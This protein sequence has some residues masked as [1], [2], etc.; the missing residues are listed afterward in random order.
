MHE[1]GWTKTVR[2][3]WFFGLFGLVFASVLVLFSPWLVVLLFAATTVVVTWPLFEWV[4]QKLGGSSGWATLVCT[5][6]LTL[7]V[8]GPFGIAVYVFVQQGLELAEQ[9]A[10]WIRSGAMEAQL[11]LWMGST[12]W[13]SV[14]TKLSLWAGPEMN[15]VAAMVEPLRDALVPLLNSIGASLPSV[16]QAIAN[17]SLDVFIFLL[18]VATLYMEGPKTLQAV[19]RLSPLDDVYEVHLFEVFR[20]LA[21]NLVV[22][23][24]VTA[25]LQG[26]VGWLGYSIAGVERALFAGVLTAVFSFVPMVGAA[27]IWLP[28][29]LYIGVNHGWA[30]GLFLVAWSV[31]LTSSVDNF[32]KPMLLRG[33]TNVHPLMIFLAVFG[34]LVWF[35]LPGV[36]LGPVLVALF[37]ALYTIYCE[38]F[39]GL[40][41]EP[42][43]SPPKSGRVLARLS[44]LF[45]WFSRKST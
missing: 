43:E 17:G 25:G 28:L 39:L 31:V 1:K 11:D 32:V 9:S 24:V 35:G 10:G 29:S 4:K 15:G 2:D 33:D 30:W 21:N 8:A 3:R 45:H 27:L 40:S 37:L 7:G 13:K 14:E 5:A 38:D 26:C 41:C 6:L 18:A 20:G 23:A 44:R 22:A 36:F 12:V 19:Q 34:G 42:V 16:L